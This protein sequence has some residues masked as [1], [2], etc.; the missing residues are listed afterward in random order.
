MECGDEEFSKNK[1]FIPQLLLV[2]FLI[3]DLWWFA[4]TINLYVDKVANTPSAQ[5]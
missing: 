3:N 5:E 2:K 1:I 4:C